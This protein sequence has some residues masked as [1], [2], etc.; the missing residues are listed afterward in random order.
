MW[1]KR[2]LIIP[3]DRLEDVL[4]WCGLCSFLSL[5]Y[6]IVKAIVAQ[7]GAQWPFTLTCAAWV[8]SVPIFGTATGYRTHRVVWVV[9][10]VYA[11]IYI[12][13]YLGALYVTVFPGMVTLLDVI[14]LMGMTYALGCTVRVLISACVHSFRLTKEEEARNRE[15]E[16]AEKRARK[17]KRHRM[18]TAPDGVRCKEGTHHRG[19]EFTEGAQRRSGHGERGEGR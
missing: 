7:P 15:A 6:F 13:L 8:L 12:G 16:K 1:L 5:G 9:M 17:K 4:G 11:P 14:D 18:G 19:T 2:S 3:K 10:L